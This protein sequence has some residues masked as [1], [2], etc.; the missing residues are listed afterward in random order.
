MQIGFM[1]KALSTHPKPYQHEWKFRRPASPSTGWAYPPKDYAK[2]GELVQ[3]VNHC[4]R[5]VRQ[6]RSSSIGTGKSGMSRISSTG[7]DA[8][9]YHKLYDYAV[10]A[11]KRALP[12]REASGAPMSPGPRSGGTRFLRGFSSH[13][14]RGPES[15]DGQAWHADRFCRVPRQGS[16]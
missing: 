4:G 2:W 8:E 16:P 7:G 1:P 6:D 11:V 15:R 10:D 14:V 5:E 9:E 13:C 3:W 12:Y